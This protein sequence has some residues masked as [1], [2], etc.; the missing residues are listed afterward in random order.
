MNHHRL[1]LGA[2]AGGLAVML[3]MPV[4]A[5]VAGLAGLRG[6]VPI[7]VGPFDLSVSGSADRLASQTLPRTLYTFEMTAR[8]RIGSGG[9]WFGS[10]VEG[11]REVD[12]LP[13]RPLLRLGFWQSYR[14]IRVS[15]DAATHAAR[16]GGRSSTLSYVTVRRDSLWDSTTSTWAHPLDRTYT[17]GDSGAPSRVALWSDLQGQVAWQLGNASVA[18][19]VGA[20]GQVGVFRPNVWT[21]I[22]AAYPFAQH[23][24]LVGAAGTEPPR[25]GLGVPATRVASLAVHV[26][27]WHSTKSFGG[28][29]ALRWIRSS[30]EWHS[31][32][33]RDIP[34]D[35][36]EVGRALRRLRGME[37]SIIDAGAS[38]PVAD[39]HRRAAR[40]L[41]REHSRE[42]GTLV[43][44]PG[45]A[46]G[47]GRFQRHGRHSG[48]SLT[49]GT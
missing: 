24:S 48:A 15:I 38:G 40:H 34:R 47:S 30:I 23:F 22:S 3:A 4:R 36:C 6:N 11:T 39:G 20:R 29:N 46:G 26:T 25:I 18:A 43:R 21:R 32:L 8:R 13:V 14:A 19:L 17:I 44:S 45:L 9:L 49:C 12:S 10:A 2:L 41:P 27:P 33:H 35:R 42:R 28:G 7:P 31:T 16:L 5:Q 37:A 1:T